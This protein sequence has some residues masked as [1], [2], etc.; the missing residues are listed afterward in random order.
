MSSSMKCFLVTGSSGFIGNSICKKL[1]SKGFKV[2]GLDV[3]NNGSTFKSFNCSIL[4]YSSIE[5]IFEDCSPDIVIHCAGPTAKSFSK[6]FEEAFNLQINGTINI[7]NS[8]KKAGI[9]KF[10]F[11]SSDHVYMCHD[12][13]HEVNEQTPL[14]LSFNK[15]EDFGRNMFATAK[16]ASE[17]ICRQ[18]F[19]NSIIFRLA[20]I[21]GPGKCTNL[22]KGMLDEA[23]NT[24][25]IEI[26][27]DGNRSVQFTHVSDV[28]DIVSNSINLKPGI[29]NIS[30]LD[31]IKVKDAAKMISQHFHAKV[32]KVLER[33]GGPMF[34][35]VSTAKLLNNLNNFNYI[36][37][38]M[39]I[40]LMVG[41][42]DD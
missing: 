1:V 13:S 23:R 15:P 8:S 12:S 10:I 2:I 5:K 39:G 4:D 19:H 32:I 26:W 31:K 6:D 18:E 24:G 27:G 25:Q 35:Y 9:E 17:A 3:I 40:K 20:S 11:L 36:P 29:Y 42:N 33:S 30:N 22:V 38:D 14:N 34:P 21:Y 41:D 37:L 16:A 7:L 28:S